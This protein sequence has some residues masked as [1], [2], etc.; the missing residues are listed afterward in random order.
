MAWTP[1]IAFVII[2]LFAAYLAYIFLGPNGALLKA[3]DNDVT[4]FVPGMPSDVPRGVA[5]ET[6]QGVREWFNEFV[7]ILPINILF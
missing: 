3:A 5:V 2:V 4:Q 7:D 6:S 1:I